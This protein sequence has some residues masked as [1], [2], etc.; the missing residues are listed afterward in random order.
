M[1]ALTCGCS[2]N[3]SNL[4]L[5]CCYERGCRMSL[6]RRVADEVNA[7]HTKISSDFCLTAFVVLNVRFSQPH[8]CLPYWTEL[9]SFMI[10]DQSRVE[11][12]PPLSGRKS[13]SLA[14]CG[15][16]FSRLLTP[17]PPH[18]HHN[19]FKPLPP[20]TGFHASPCL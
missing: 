3:I 10:A 12:T 6:G 11:L 15:Y 13:A 2:R 5:Y 19:S 7:I 4:V 20:N 17:H 1:W 18:T 14:S 8:N 16:R 9:F